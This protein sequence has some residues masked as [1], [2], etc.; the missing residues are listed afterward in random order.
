MVQQLVMVKKERE[1]SLYPSAPCIRCRQDAWGVRPDGT[2]YYCTQCITEDQ[3]NKRYAYLL[4][5]RGGN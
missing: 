2:G 1:V 5:E 3:V 4:K